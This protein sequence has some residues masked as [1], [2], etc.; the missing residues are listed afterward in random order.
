M[1]TFPS[2]RRRPSLWVCLWLAAV[3]STPFACGRIGYESIDRSDTSS[4]TEGQD[5]DAPVAGSGVSTP[6]ETV[7]GPLFEQVFFAGPASGDE[8]LTDFTLF[9]VRE[10]G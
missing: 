6:L 7:P 9:V 5:N 1:L 4:A 10:G 2:Q 8:D 3:C